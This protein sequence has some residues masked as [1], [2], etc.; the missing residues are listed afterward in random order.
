MRRL[1]PA[2]P[3]L[4]A[5]FSL[6]LAPAA[7]ATTVYRTVDDRGVVTFSDSPPEGEVAVETVEI[8]TPAPPSDD[9]QQQRLEDMR[10]TTDRMVAD[11]QAREKHRA[12]MRELQARSQPPPVVEYAPQPATYT[13]GYWGGYR[14]WR[15]GPG[16]RPEHPIARPPLRPHPARPGHANPG[17]FNDYPA[18]LI[19]RGYN[20]QA[21]EAFR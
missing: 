15:P 7:A 17:R 1:I 14:Y 11:R 12:E 20:R 6:L 4:A 2:I 3:G 13:S 19:R 21:R 9:V 8:D 10:E 5:V 16:H 18:S